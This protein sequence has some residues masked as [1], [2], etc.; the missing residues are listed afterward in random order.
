VKKVLLVL[1]FALV[2]AVGVFSG[3]KAFKHYKSDQYAATAVPYI[4]RVVPEISRWN[5]EVTKRYMLPESLGKTPDDKIDKIVR[6]LSRLGALVHM[7]EPQF[8]SE[9]SSVVIAGSPAT[10]VTYDVNLEYEKGSA[11]M[12]LGLLARGNDFQVQN[13]NVQ[14]QA[15]AQ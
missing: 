10:I 14:S 7:D 11:V 13:F 5:P 3:I 6:S 4:K 1:G 12:T 9:D 2:V 8:S 15:L